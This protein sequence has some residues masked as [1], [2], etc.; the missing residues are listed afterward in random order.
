[1]ELNNTNFDN[2]KVDSKNN[3]VYKSIKLKNNNEKKQFESLRKYI[4]YISKHIDFIPDVKIYENKEYEAVIG[5]NF[6][7]NISSFYN[8]LENKHP[9]TN[10]DLKNFYF[11]VNG[12]INLNFFKVSNSIFKKNDFIICF[13]P[14]GTYSRFLKKIYLDKNNKIWYIPDYRDIL[15]LTLDQW[16]FKYTFHTKDYIYNSLSYVYR[17]VQHNRMFESTNKEIKKYNNEFNNVVKK[18]EELIIEL[19]KNRIKYSQVQKILGDDLFNEYF[20]KK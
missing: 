16:L 9:F 17:K 8:L 13:Q 2:I 10:D 4:F 6:I 20:G 19:E 3:T 15:I 14:I 12:S 18:H 11:F 5:N 1:M 7:N